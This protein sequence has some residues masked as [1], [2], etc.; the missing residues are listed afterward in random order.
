MIVIVFLATILFATTQGAM[1]GLSVGGCLYFIFLCFAYF[2]RGHWISFA[3]WWGGMIALALVSVM[4]YDRSWSRAHQWLQD[5]IITT[6]TITT[7]TQPLRYLYE[8]EWWRNF[9]YNS[10][11]DHHIGDR[12]VTI[13]TVIPVVKDSTSKP[14]TREVLFDYQRRQ[15]MKW[16]HGQIKEL[17]FVSDGQSDSLI[18]KIRKN[19]TY[20]VIQTY[21]STP[22]AGLVL[23]MLIGDKSLIPKDTYKDFVDSGLVHIIA[24][25]GG[26]IIMIV[27][28]LGYLLFRLPFYVRL[29]FIL[30]VVMMYGLVCGLDSSV[31]RAMIMGGLG[32]IATMLGRSIDIWRSLSIALVVMLLRNPYFLAYDIGF[33]FSFCAII[34][35]IYMDQYVKLPRHFLLQPLRAYLLPSLGATLGVLPSLLFFTG[36][37]NLIWLF[38]N[39]L[40]V[41]LLPFVMIYGFVSTRLH[42]RTQRKIV[43]LPV[44]RA[45]ERIYSVAHR[46]AVHGIYLSVDHRY[47]KWAIV[48]LAWVIVWYLRYRDSHI[49]QIE[50]TWV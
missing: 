13:G 30:M 27:I 46:F 41:P 3:L 26:N 47:A 10:T 18:L 12:I 50:T 7:Q 40:V 44:Q 45:T 14:L 25:S 1:R 48:C 5:Y 4:Y 34:G 42:Q 32:I 35:L 6:G 17:S 16:Y 39:I 8:D 20:A 15:Y 31:V 23:G 21:G 43:L 49:W 37:I 24:V 2:R 9:V 19:L 38:A 22:S 29:F 33:I 28:F 11:A 36:Q